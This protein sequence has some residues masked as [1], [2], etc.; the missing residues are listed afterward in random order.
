M[1]TAFDCDCLVDDITL[2]TCSGREAHLET[3]YA[4]N[5]AAIYNNIISDDFAFDRCCLAN[6]Q[7]MRANVALNRTLNLNVASRL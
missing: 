2:N 3:A 1:R 5:N 7:K 4:A 6:G